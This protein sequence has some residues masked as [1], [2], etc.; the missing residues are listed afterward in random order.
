MNVIDSSSSETYDST[1]DKTGCTNRLVLTLNG[2]VFFA[3]K[4]TI[5]EHVARMPTLKR[6]CWRNC[7]DVDV[8]DDIVP[9]RE[10]SI[11]GNAK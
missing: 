8:S 2:R 3:R 4:E 1:K 10:E 9:K 7:V 5:A 6:A 11:G